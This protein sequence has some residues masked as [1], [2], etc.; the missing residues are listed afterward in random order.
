[1]PIHSKQAAIEEF[2][3]HCKAI[4]KKKKKCAINSVNL[5]PIHSKQAAIEEFVKHCKAIKKKKKMRHK[6]S[7]LDAH[8]QQTS[9][10]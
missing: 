6:L 7:K 5:M 2:V 10:Y 8:P 4:K 3:K 9:C 1:M